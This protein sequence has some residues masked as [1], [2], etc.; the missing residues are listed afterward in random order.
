MKVVEVPN[1][2]LGNGLF[3]Y[4]A[5]LVFRFVYGGERITIPQYRKIISTTS[6]PVK[7][8]KIGDDDFINWCKMH[9]SFPKIN[10]DSICIFDGYFQLDDYKKFRGDIIG[11]MKSH[12]NEVIYGTNLQNQLIENTVRE[13]IIPPKNIAQYKIVV[14]V[15]LEDFLIHNNVIHP[16]DLYK[17]IAELVKENPDEKICF[18]CNQMTKEI[19]FKYKNYFRDNFPEIVFESNDVITDFHIMKQSTIL[20]CSLS[21]LS[22]CAALLSETVEKVYVPKNKTSAH[23][24]YLQPIWNTVVYD[25]RFCGEKELVEFFKP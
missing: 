1:G 11:Y 3:R 23:Q 22:W 15:R 17:I 10:T 8:I 25:N 21:T 13:I 14:H 24:L 2:R 4:L 5:A 18:L 7:Q 16:E 20:V 19:E 6:I 12:T 9:P